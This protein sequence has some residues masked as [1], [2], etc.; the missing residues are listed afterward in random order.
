[1]STPESLPGSGRAAEP[2]RPQRQVGSRSGRE[3]FEKVAPFGSLIVLAGLFIFF[4]VDEPERFLDRE[5]LISILNEGALLGIVACGLTVPLITLN[6][7]LSIGAMATLSGLTTALLL[8][9][10]ISLGLVI[11]M[12]IALGV[13]VGLVNGFVVVRLGVSAF[14]GTLAVMTMLQGLGTWWAGGASV[15]IQNKAFTSWATTEVA[16]I[17]IPVFVAAAFFLVFWFVI[18]RTSI[19][20]RV[21][22]VGANPEAARLAGV[23]TQSL[24]F[25]AF[26]ACAIAS[27]VAGILLTSKLFGG[28]QGSGEPFLL[29]A[30]AAV[31]IGA[32][33]LRLGQCHILG[34]LIGVLL[35]SVME[36]GLLLLNEPAYVTDLAKGGIL[37]AAVTLAG[38]SGTMKRMART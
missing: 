26:I 7:D 19:G 13:V 37:V 29:D 1:V 22:A 20:R 10:S 38:A 28:Y 12:V 14:I 33:T 24:R 2:S 16:E 25:G 35:L 6:F 3:I 36:N 21:Y 17:P 4:A 31:F 34:T 18:E 5:N 11:V 27:T 8:Q 32:V 9:Q 23:R 30:Y 15:S